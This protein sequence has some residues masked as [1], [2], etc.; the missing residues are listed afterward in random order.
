MLALVR[1]AARELERGG[2]PARAVPLLATRPGV[3]DQSGL[4]AAAR[5][6]NLH[7]ALRV[8]PGP[9]RRLAGGVP[10]IAGA[11]VCDDVVTTGATLVEA[12]RALRAVGVPV[13]GSA[14]VAATARRGAEGR[15]RRT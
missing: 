9:L 8:R 7:G 10:E 4:D 5:A 12:Q 11:V 13:L 14:T 15:R 3:A 1:A 6:A 2:V